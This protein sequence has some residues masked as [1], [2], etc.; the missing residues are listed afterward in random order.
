MEKMPPKPIKLKWEFNDG[1]MEKIDEA[2]KDGLKLVDVSL[3][4][5]FVHNLIN[6]L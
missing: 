1:L 4:L 5:H 3:I 6:F 2:Y